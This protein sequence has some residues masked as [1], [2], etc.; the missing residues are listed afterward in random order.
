MARSK[1]ATLSATRSRCVTLSEKSMRHDL[2]CRGKAAGAAGAPE[3]TSGRQ[4]GLPDGSCRLPAGRRGCDGAAPA[5]SAQCD[6]PA[7]TS[8]R[9]LSGVVLIIKPRCC[10]RSAPQGLGLGFRAPAERRPKSPPPL[11]LTSSFGSLSP[12]TCPGR[13]RRPQ[14]ELIHKGALHFSYGSVQVQT[15][16]S[17]C[18]VPSRTTCVHFTLRRMETDNYRAALPKPSSFL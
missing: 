16:A 5:A 12:E 8:A 10:F 6:C 18:L 15:N 17:A 11:F 1:S 9:R 3:T 7:A 2:R 14:S 13:C 4:G